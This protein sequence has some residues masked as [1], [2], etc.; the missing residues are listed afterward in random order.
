MKYNI[1]F[2][3]TV[4]IF[5]VTILVPVHAASL[6]LDAENENIAVSQ[7]ATKSLELSLFTYHDDRI[8]LSLK[9]SKEWMSLNVVQP[10]LNKSE[11]MTIE[12]LLSP[13]FKTTPGVYKIDIIATSQLTGDKSIKIIYISLLEGTETIVI[14]NIIVD[15]KFEPFSDV[16][17]STM[18]RNGKSVTLHGLTVNLTLFN[19]TGSVVGISSDI[20]E[21]LQFNSTIENNFTMKLGKGI[22]S[23]IHKV[24]AI[25]YDGNIKLDE[26]ISPDFTIKSMFVEYREDPIH[27]GIL[28]IGKKIVIENVG[29]ENGAVNIEEDVGILAFLYT[30]DAPHS[31]EGSIYKWSFE[32]EPS[33]SIT[34]QYYTNYLPIIVLILILGVIFW[35]VFTIIFTVKLS[36]RIMH[37]RKLEDGAQFTIGIEVQ[38]ETLNDIN[39]VV[40]RDFIPHIFTVENQATIKPLKKKT[41][42]GTELIWRLDKIKKGDAR[43]ISYTI[44]S[45]IGISG[46]IRLASSNVRYKYKGMRFKKESNGVEMG[47][48]G[49]T[50]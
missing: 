50:S 36:K 14:E 19:S 29:N 30:G 41:P 6:I 2:C 28:G 15:G 12:L 49:E 27:L 47:T 11:N 3:I 35:Y 16:L 18:V 31:K 4:A 5:L 26:Q 37:Q 10:R 43:V 34:V 39:D 7:G 38:N 46:T 13:N 44:R 21:T 23:G 24:R 17:I 48:G 45:K 22:S 32:L 42:F 40:I 8:I 1:L 25:I 33:Q 20:I 9:D